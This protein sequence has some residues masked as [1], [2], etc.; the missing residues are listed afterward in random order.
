MATFSSLYRQIRLYCRSVPETT[1]DH[2]IRL[3]AREFCRKS[4]YVRETIIV[5]ELAGTAYYDIESSTPTETEILGIVAVQRDERPL[6]P[7]T[8]QQDVQQKE[9]Q[10]K[11]WIFLPPSTL[12]LA[13]YPAATETN[14]LDVYVRV[15]LT[16]KADCT[17]LPDDL[18]VQYEQHLA[19]GA[20][21]YLAEMPGEE[22]SN[23]KVAM[24]AYKKFSEAMYQAKSNAVFGHKPWGNTIALRPFAI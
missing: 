24:E 7:P 19:Y 12:E 17:V 22:W 4:W 6:A 5:T 1:M 15:A 13:P 3:A 10:P 21:A 8:T 16:P 14:L 9:G 2:A 11:T 18:F 20:I 23:D